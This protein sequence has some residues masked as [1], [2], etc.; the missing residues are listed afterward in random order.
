MKRLSIL[1]FTILSVIVLIAACAPAASDA[2]AA[3][4]KLADIK[5]AGKI[6]VGTSPDY[7]PFESVDSAGNFVGF[8]IELMQ[9]IAKR[10]GV[11]L[12]W[13]DM[14]FDSLI[15]AVQG[16]KLDASISGFNYDEERDKLVDFTDPYFI[17][18]DAFLV[19]ET[20]TD[21]LSTPEDAANYKIGCQ[22]GTTQDGWLTDNLVGGGLMSEDNLTRYERFDSAVLDLKAGRVDVVMG[23]DVVVKALMKSMGGL[24]IALEADVSSGPVHMIIPE[25]A[26]TLQGEIN[27]IIADMKSE[28]LIDQLILEFFAE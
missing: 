16:G 8:D 5:S 9:E 12:V 7:P 10:M 22:T 14:P 27:K 25:G 4:D 13:Q 1:L 2:P 11:E 20:F 15:A 21:T 17:A 24:K 3:P 6:V 28:G 18:K 26:T 19:A 23:D